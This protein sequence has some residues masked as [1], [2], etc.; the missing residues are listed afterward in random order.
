MI[1]HEISTSVRI[2]LS[3]QCPLKSIIPSCALSLK[4]QSES[5]G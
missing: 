5:D 1:P 3:L 4:I 2:E